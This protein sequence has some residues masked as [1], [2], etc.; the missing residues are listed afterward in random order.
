MH[1]AA[2]MLSE[3]GVFYVLM[4]DY[5]YKALVKNEI[6]ARSE[7]GIE[8]QN[9]NVENFADYIL[10]TTYG[11]AP[12]CKPLACRRLLSRQIPGEKLGV[13]RIYR[14]HILDSINNDIS[15]PL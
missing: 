8:E 12:I 7:H 4:I 6:C 3:R 10:L 14:P 2:D 15:I 13:Y 11:S 5:N 1:Q 9:I